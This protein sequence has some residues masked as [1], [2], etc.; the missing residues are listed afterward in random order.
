MEALRT[1]TDP[2]KLAKN[3][4][5]NKENYARNKA[6]VDEIKT[7]SGCISC[8]YN[9]HPAA[10]DFNHIDPSTK[11]FDVST[12]LQQYCWA[13][14]EE[15]IAKCEVLCANCHR[16]HTYDNHPTRLHKAGA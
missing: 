5:R 8:G 7:T 4:Q 15:E 6:K 1:K 16:I 10:L 12:R 11:K 13:R 14:L 2:E 3:K 9:S